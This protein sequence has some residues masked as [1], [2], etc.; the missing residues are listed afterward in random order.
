MI[1]GEIITPEKLRELADK[2]EDAERK[3]QKAEKP[4]KP[5]R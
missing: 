4:R 3:A 5:N 2:I 1:D